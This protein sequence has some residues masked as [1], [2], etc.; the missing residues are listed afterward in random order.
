[1]AMRAWTLWPDATTKPAVLGDLLRFAAW[2]ELGHATV[3]SALGDAA[4]N[5]TRLTLAETYDDLG[6]FALVT[7]TVE[8]MKITDDWQTRLRGLYLMASR[9]YMRGDLITA[10]E[11]L[12]VAAVAIAEL[13]HSLATDSF[14]MFSRVYDHRYAL[15][16]RRLFGLLA[17]R[18]GVPKDQVDECSHQL[19][20]LVD[21]A[22]GRVGRFDKSLIHDAFEDQHSALVTCY[23]RE[24]DT[25]PSVEGRVNVRVDISTTGKIVTVDTTVDPDTQAMQS[26]GT[27]I[28]K[29][30]EQIE[31]PRQVYES[32][33]IVTYPLTFARPK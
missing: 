29:S 30:I 32:E 15:A 27:C 2:A 11:H 31:L 1:M 6:R 18:F 26:L 10:A 20:S 25:D 23:Q 4:D 17:D 19:D 28:R 16:A 24:I 12:D 22:Y 7:P 13:T 21:D 33:V 8:S 9:A 14:R 3:V 5:K